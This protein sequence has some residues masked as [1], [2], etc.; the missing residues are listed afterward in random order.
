MQHHAL[1]EIVE[2]HVA[3]AVAG[4][5]AGTALVV[6]AFHRLAFQHGGLD[7]LVGIFGLHA[8][9][10]DAAGVEDDQRAEFAEAVA[11]GD[12]D[13]HAV[14]QAVVVDGLLQG[15][16]HVHAARRGTAGAAADEN[17]VFFLVF[18]AFVVTQVE[19]G[20]GL[21]VQP[22]KVVNG[23]ETFEFKHIVLSFRPGSCRGYRECRRGS[24]GRGCCR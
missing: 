5:L 14:V 6:Q 10:E 2:E 16:A 17:L 3:V 8:D 24:G 20:P 11:A 21:L 18:L 7:E 23:V 22:G 4:R 9:I 12:H 1:L 13:A 19:Q 15:V